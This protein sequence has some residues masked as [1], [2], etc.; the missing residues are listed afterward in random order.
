[1]IGVYT[2]WLLVTADAGRID[3]MSTDRQ[4]TAVP[5]EDAGETTA[6]RYEGGD[7]HECP[8]RQ[9]NGRLQKSEFLKTD[10]A[11]I[12]TCNGAACLAP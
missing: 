11:V 5:V 4:Q 7:P 3:R 2:D 10:G 12:D 1:M 8:R 6:T 9:V